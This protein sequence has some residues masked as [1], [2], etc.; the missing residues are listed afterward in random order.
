MKDFKNIC[1][2]YFLILG[3]MLLINRSSIY[4]ISW[5]VFPLTSII[6]LAIMVIIFIKLNVNLKSVLIF[7]SIILILMMI[8]AID[9]NS[10][11]GKYSDYGL[12]I[13]SLVFPLEL[14]IALAILTLPFQWIIA[15]LI[16]YNLLNYSCIIVL[17]CIITIAMMTLSVMK[18]FKRK[19]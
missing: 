10:L 17:I 19:K 2:T 1:I 18:L 5:L 6:I 14:L 7:F 8:I 13:P 15:L 16:K 9:S 4:E 12:Y 3:L 11:F